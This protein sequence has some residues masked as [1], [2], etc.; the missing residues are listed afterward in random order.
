MESTQTMWSH[1][2]TKALQADRHRHRECAEQLGLF[3]AL[4]N[5]ALVKGGDCMMLNIWLHN[6]VYSNK[7]E[8]H[9]NKINRRS[10]ASKAQQQQR[11]S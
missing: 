9:L 6:M 8:A 7:S 10:F 3:R 2:L 4:N 5:E 1:F 11:S